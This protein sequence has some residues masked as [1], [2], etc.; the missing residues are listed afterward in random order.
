MSPE[1]IGNNAGNTVE[2]KMG[3]RTTHNK[4]LMVVNVI[5]KAILTFVK[6]L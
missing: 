4:L 2:S 1:L 6:K 5:E 3:N